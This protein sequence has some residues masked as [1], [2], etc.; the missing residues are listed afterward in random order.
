M[1]DELYFEDFFP[2]QSFESLDSDWL[3][4]REI[5]RNMLLVP[6]RSQPTASSTP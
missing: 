6:N 1:Q 3:T 4:V 2:G 5:I